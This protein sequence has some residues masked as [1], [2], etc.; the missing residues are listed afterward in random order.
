MVRINIVN[1][2]ENDLNPTIENEPEIG[3]RKKRKRSNI[4]MNTSN[5]RKSQQI[6]EE[7]NNNKNIET[8]NINK[9]E[10]TSHRNIYYI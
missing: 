3:I 1:L 9:N 7:M 4:K 6:K 5:Y 2:N 8:Q 10:K